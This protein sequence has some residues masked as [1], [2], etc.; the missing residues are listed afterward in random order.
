MIHIF[1]IFLS[2]TLSCFITA[3]EPKVLLGI[4]V[5]MTSE[6]PLL[7]KGKRIGLV[8]N[9][10]ALNKDLLSTI[11]LLKRDGR[12]RG[13]TLTALFAPEHGINGAKH[14]SI[15]LSD[16][17]DSDGIPIYS[18]HGKV[19]R[20]T[21]EMFGNV[22]II[23]YD[24][25]DIGS[26][27]YTYISTL[28]H[29]MEECAKYGV[30]VFVLDRPN[31]ING[32]VVDGPMLEE[33]WRSFVGYINVPYCHGMTVGELA[34]L[35]NGEYS[36]GCQLTVVPMKG[37]KREMTFA[38]TQLTWVPTSPYIPE[39]TT[40]YYYPMTGL[41]GELN[42]VSIGIGYTLPFKIIGA[43]WIDAQ[44]FAK[45]LNAQK[46]PG[47]SFIPFYYRPF[48]GK[49]K[50]EDCQGVQIAV[51]D[52]KIFRPVTTQ[53]LLL[54]VLKSLYPAKFSAAMK[55]AEPRQEMVSKVSGTDAVYQILSHKEPAVWKLRELH[56][57]ERQTFMSVRK[58]YLI[59][60]D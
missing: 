48:Y 22:D 31:P 36:I 37:W 7:F 28:F 19:R 42:L 50:N 33:K 47:I 43:P 53:Y 13:Y 59:Y 57:K 14:A 24:I 45:T 2:L 39:A 8:T 40:V 18:L 1:S 20:P 55:E 6:I 51:T 25:Q 15:L 4:D 29:V 56:Q 60:S 41:I 26:R 16:D 38:D 3:H 52:P 12:N 21:K 34:Q 35:F 11:D 46:F 44:K 17:K 30:P 23:I 27:S 49:Y 5:F 58:K 32:L 10:T 9:H 54:G